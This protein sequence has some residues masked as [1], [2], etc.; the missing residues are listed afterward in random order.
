[1]PNLFS[2]AF[3]KGWN[4]VR[5]NPQILFTVALSVLIVGSFVSAVFIFSELVTETQDRFERHRHSSLYDAFVLYAEDNLGNGE[6]LTEAIQDI[7]QQ[8][9]TFQEFRVLQSIEGERIIIAS[10]NEDEIG[11]VDTNADDFYQFTYAHTDKSFNFP[12]EK[13]DERYFVTVRAIVNDE[14]EIA[15]WV[16]SGSSLSQIDALTRR[17]VVNAYLYLIVIVGVILALLVRH[18]RIID[19]TTLYRRLK[20]VDQMKDDFVSMAS[21]ELRTPLTAIRGYV[22]LVK[23]SP[24]LR[25]EDK[26]SLQRVEY[27]AKQLDE[28]V[29][30]ILDVARLEQGRLK[31]SFTDVDVNPIV[32]DVVEQLRP[33]SDKK[34]LELRFD[35]KEVPHISAD[36]DRLKQTIV[37][38]VGNAIKYTEKGSVTVQTYQEQNR[39]FIRINDTGYG[40]SAEAQKRLFQKFYRVK[41]DKTQAIRGT[42]LGLWITHE[43]VT[44]MKG[45]ITVESIEGVGSHFI[46]SFPV[47]KT[48]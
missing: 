34:Q 25:E 36:S 5:N 38:L 18:A 1:M 35:Q 31:F 28:L 12:I 48:T 21:H 37:N 42:G 4:L 26:T 16:Y 19:Y 44:Q 8:N 20:E 3:S 27:S 17:E 10:L 41:T 43:I 11:S 29:N 23:G 7:S 9:E 6:K 22:D 47:K 40:I 13:D 32:A 30:D 33:V 24:G 46:V 14:D 39:V 2:Q 15:G 45:T